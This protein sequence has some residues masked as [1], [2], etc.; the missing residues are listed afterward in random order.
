MSEESEQ[1]KARTKAF[2]V[3]ILRLID[4]FD[5]RVSLKIVAWQL[6]KSATSTGANYRAA[7]T[8]R[9]RAEYLSKMQTSSEE[10]DEAL[11]WLEVL[12]D[13]GTVTS[14]RLPALTDESRQLRSIIRKSL[15]TAR[16]NDEM[17]GT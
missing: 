6:G 3:S 12:N 17:R 9:S 1:I 13:L 14:P 16:R 4:T 11:F 8:A 5:R 15:G 2:G 10:S 7:C